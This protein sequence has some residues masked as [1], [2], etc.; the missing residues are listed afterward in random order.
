M[1][2]K[3]LAKQF[4]DYP[5]VLTVKEVGE[6]LSISTKLVYN[7]LK[8]GTI[9]SVRIGREHK[10]AKINLIDFIRCSEKQKSRKSVPKI[11]WTVPN[12]C[13]MLVFGDKKNCHRK[14]Q[15]RKQAI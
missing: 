10:I 2:K 13:G 7:L 15:E 5:D 3:E 9:P 12:P 11:V 1:T 6:L 4:K 14:P 8:E